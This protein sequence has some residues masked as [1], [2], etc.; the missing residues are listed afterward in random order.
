MLTFATLGPQG[1]NHELVTKEY[2][3]FHGIDDATIVLVQNF[4][5]A[6]DGLLRGEYDFVVQCAVHPDTPQ[7]MGAK[8]SQ[9]FAVD[10]FISRSKD[11][12][13]LTRKE[14]EHPESIGLLLPATESYVDIGKWRRKF[15]G[16]SLPIIF[17]GLLAGEYD[18][19]L[20]YLEYADQYPDRVRVDKII[21]SPDDVWIVYG[22]ERTS[23][24]AIQAWRDAP[25]SG[26]IERKLASKRTIRSS[27]AAL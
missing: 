21:G 15:A 24:G 22:L 3:K 12:A 14:I 8:F 13:V 25:I 7:T 1:T 18:S 26:I 27:D 10:S 23:R 6:T 2:I 17:E 11:L 19:A 9:I 4:E 5:Q 20:V 16:P